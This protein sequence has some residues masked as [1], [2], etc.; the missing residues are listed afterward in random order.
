M[1]TPSL[2]AK[3]ILWINGMASRLEIPGPLTPMAVRLRGFS[4]M[5]F[6][7]FLRVNLSFR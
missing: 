3:E 4:G 6:A 1:V 7:Q 5:I 2:A